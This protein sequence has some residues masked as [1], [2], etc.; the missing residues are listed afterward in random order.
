MSLPAYCLFL[1]GA[2]QL[3]ACVACASNIRSASVFLHPAYG[4]AH[5]P[6]NC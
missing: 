1:V 5:T 4:C 6:E 3:A 2:T